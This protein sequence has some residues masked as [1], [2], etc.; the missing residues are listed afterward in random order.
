M[1]L[2][3]IFLIMKKLFFFILISTC[4]FTLI[5]FSSCSLTKK[6]CCGSEQNRISFLENRIN[7]LERILSDTT[8]C[9]LPELTIND[10]RVNNF[11][12]SA[13]FIYN[14]CRHCTTELPVPVF[15]KIYGR[16]T[17]HEDQLYLVQ[18]HY[19]EDIS[20]QINNYSGGFYYKGKL[21]VVH[22]TTENF[23]ESLF[24]E[25][26]CSLRIERCNLR[27]I[28]SC[29]TATFSLKKGEIIEYICDDPL[30]FVR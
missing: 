2:I 9:Y 1:S 26:D 6:F 7:F 15:F 23:D 11:L 10:I 19:T 24:K 17:L 21:F 30:P 20:E 13:L 28:G 25:S 8:V 29:L 27:I 18:S 12:D 16:R 22:R 3:N 4:L 5:G 14:D